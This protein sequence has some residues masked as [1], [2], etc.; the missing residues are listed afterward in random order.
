LVDLASLA[1][2]VGAT[3][4]PEVEHRPFSQKEDKIIIRAHARFGNKWATIARLLNGRTYNAIKN[5]WNSTLK[6]KCSSMTE[7]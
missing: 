3:N 4:F 6:C 1:I 2:Y 7:D 5:H